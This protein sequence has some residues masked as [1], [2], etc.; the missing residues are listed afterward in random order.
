MEDQGNFL[1]EGMQLEEVGTSVWAHYS[2]YSYVPGADKIFA[3]S[4]IWRLPCQRVHNNKE[5]F[6]KCLET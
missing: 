2:H 6:Y 5:I 3:L 1:T 4:S